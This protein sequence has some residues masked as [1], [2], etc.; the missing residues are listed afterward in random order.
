MDAWKRWIALSAAIALLALF[1]CGSDTESP[2]APEDDGEQP[3]P[4]DTS[5]VRFT[6][7]TYT[8][9][10]DDGTVETGLTLQWQIWFASTTGRSCRILKYKLYSD[11]DELLF[12]Q[13]NPVPA[14]IASGLI[15]S[16]KERWIPLDGPT[17]AGDYQFRVLYE[18]GRITT[19]VDDSTHWTGPFTTGLIDT[20]FTA[21]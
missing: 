4:V 5:V 6:R 8:A 16:G 15:L 17:A 14:M 2:V 11:R 12:E 7:L 10:D 19:G 9:Y 3:A 21:E 18:L 20:T 13:L 1:G